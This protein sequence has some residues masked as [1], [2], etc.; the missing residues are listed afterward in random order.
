MRLIA[1]EPFS[2]GT[3]YVLRTDDD[4]S[5][6]VC[7]Y[8]RPLTAEHAKRQSDERPAYADYGDRT[9][10]W[11]IEVS[12]MAGCPVR[13][14]FCATGSLRTRNLT[15]E[16]IVAQVEFVLAQHPTID[17]TRSAEFLIAYERM[18]EPFL[19]VEAVRGAIDLVER[20]Y[21]GTM[22]YVST[23]GVK[24][25]DFSWIEGNITLQISLHSFDEAR[26]NHLI[27]FRKKMSIEE[28][29]RI[30]TRSSR[31]TTLNLALAD[32]ADFDLDALRRNFDREHFFIKL[33]Q[34][35]ANFIA[36]ENGMDA[37]VFAQASH[38]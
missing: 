9:Q 4:F 22:H 38:G 31:K 35:N 26:R 13:C 34:I 1:A 8:Y 18:G 5:I 11:R 6:E 12:T 27:P 19:N 36:D 15:A 7:E 2:C 21:P 16:E 23:I 14:R 20:R 17:P 24:G 3:A 28:L 30:R 37:G 33:S 25:A 10:L 32:E 29:G